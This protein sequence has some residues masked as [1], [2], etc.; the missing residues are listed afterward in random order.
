MYT[1]WTRVAPQEGQP[2]P[3]AETAFETPAKFTA[4]AGAA[5]MSRDKRH[6]GGRASYERL[7]C[8]VSRATRYS[9][10][11]PSLIG[12]QCVMATVTRPANLSHQNGSN[13]LNVCG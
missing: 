12:T 4:R 2:C 9:V 3:W 11:L 13:S 5:Y 8:L 1:P 7:D 10:V 6:A